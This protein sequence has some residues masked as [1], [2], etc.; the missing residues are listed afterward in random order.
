M[1]MD[2]YHAK[3]NNNLIGWITN[4]PLNDGWIDY[5]DILRIKKGEYFALSVIS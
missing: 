4:M 5:F 3:L 2:N 1:A